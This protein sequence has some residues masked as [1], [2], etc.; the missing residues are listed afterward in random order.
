MYKIYVTK[1]AAKDFPKLTASH[2]DKKVRA[3]IEILKNDPYQNPPSYEKLIGD[4]NGLY[5]RRIN[6]KHRLVYEIDEKNKFIKIISV[7]SHYD[8]N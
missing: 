7:W 1:D 5:Y 6:L 4:L 3:L 8:E 2:L